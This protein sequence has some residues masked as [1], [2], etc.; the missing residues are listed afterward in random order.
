M[1]HRVGTTGQI[2]AFG[3]DLMKLFT[4]DTGEV[5]VTATRTAPNAW[6]VSAEGIAD[7]VVSDRA[8]AITEMANYALQLHSGDGYSMLVP[9]G[10]ADLP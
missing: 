1:P 6:T 5:A 3:N 7:L 4:T 8:T 2:V 9:A 10:L